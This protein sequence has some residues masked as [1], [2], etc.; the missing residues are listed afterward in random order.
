GAGLSSTVAA[1]TSMTSGGGCAPRLALGRSAKVAVVGSRSSEP[2][3]RILR[4]VRGRWTRA[5]PS[6]QPS[7]ATRT[8][9]NLLGAVPERPQRR[10]VVGRRV[11]RRLDR[12][13]AEALRRVVGDLRAGERVRRL[14]A[15]RDR[16]ADTL[17]GLFAQPPDV[18]RGLR[19]ALE[20]H[21]SISVF[22]AFEL[23]LLGVGDVHLRLDLHQLVV[24]AVE[25][26]D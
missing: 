19:D 6:P 10:S 24:D 1:S 12:P 20:D 18:L 15:L 25:L 3:Q 7:N 8:G 23:G 21:H 26:D 11:D 16:L 4:Y 5:L 2:I 22:G 14:A 17:I 9:S 13:A